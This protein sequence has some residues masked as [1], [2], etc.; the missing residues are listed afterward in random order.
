MKAP[1]KNPGFVDVVRGLALMPERDLLRTLGDDQNAYRVLRHLFATG[2][3]SLRDGVR[4][5]AEGFGTSGI[6][7]NDT[8]VDRSVLVRLPRDFAEKHQVMLVYR[9]GDRITA[10]AADP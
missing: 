4:M 10:V 3:V 1:P 5:W 8:L 7:I 9:L 6:D 2:Q